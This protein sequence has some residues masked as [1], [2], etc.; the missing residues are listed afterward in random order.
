LLKA[1]QDYL[2]AQNK[3]SIKVNQVRYNTNTIMPHSY[4]ASF[5][6]APNG[7]DQKLLND[8][9]AYLQ[10]HKTDSALSVKQVSLTDSVMLIIV[11]QFS[12]KFT[13]ETYME[14]MRADKSFIKKIE[15]YPFD[16]FIISNFNLPLLL[17]SKDLEAYIKFYKAHYL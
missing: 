13:S 11:K 8:F 16:F 5:K 7:D 15:K 2:A 3:E 9:T 4:I 6:K 12:G 1:S 17:E 10:T 14:D